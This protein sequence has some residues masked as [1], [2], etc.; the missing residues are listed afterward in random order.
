MHS[1]KNDIVI[2]LRRNGH[3]IVVNCQ[4]REVRTTMACLK[5]VFIFTIS[6]LLPRASHIYPLLSTVEIP[7]A[8]DV[9]STRTDCD[10][11]G[12]YVVPNV[13]SP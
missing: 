13:L 4:A 7:E 3:V 6:S 12:D 5:A 8:V 1:F 2:Q 11:A 9:R 10:K